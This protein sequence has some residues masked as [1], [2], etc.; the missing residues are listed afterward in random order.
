MAN[1]NPDTSG[2]IPFTKGVS[3]NPDGRPSKIYT[4]LKKSGYSKDDIRTAYNEIAWQDVDELQKVFKD[5]KSPA[6]IKVIAHAFKRAIEK[7]DYRYVNEIIQQ[8]I[9]QPKQD[10]DTNLNI[11]AF[12]V[13]FNEPPKTDEES[14]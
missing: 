3:G 8:V 1:P 14:K 2:L 10:V 12:N 13:K 4:V 5:P 7:G 11:T 9:G 6:I